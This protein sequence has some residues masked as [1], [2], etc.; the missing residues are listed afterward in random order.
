MNLVARMRKAGVEVDARALFSHP[1][2]AQLAGCVLTQV[3]RVEVPQAAIPQ[4]GRR[5]RI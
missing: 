2:V 5:R 3:Q 1:T 4:L